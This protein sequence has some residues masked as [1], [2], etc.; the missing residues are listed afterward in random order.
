MKPLDCA[1]LFA[2]SD[3]LLL[4]TN[5]QQQNDIQKLLNSDSWIRKIT[6]KKHLVRLQVMYSCVN[7]HQPHESCSLSQGKTVIDGDRQTD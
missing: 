5:L 4:Y 7:H 1:A 6:Q 2:V 3:T